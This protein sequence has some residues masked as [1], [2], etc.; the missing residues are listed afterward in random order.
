MNGPEE[1]TCRELVQLV[2]EYLDG[3]LPAPEHVQ[4][5]QH[6]VLCTGCQNHL[7]QMRQTLRVLHRLPPEDLPE[8]VMGELLRTFRTWQTSGRLG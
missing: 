4:F 2:T 8:P 3:A 5:E 7:S 1:I 6:L